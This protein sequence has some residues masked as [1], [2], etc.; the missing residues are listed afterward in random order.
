MLPEEGSDAVGG[1][2]NSS[3]RRAM[4]VIENED[5]SWN[6]SYHTPDPA[7]VWS[8]GEDEEADVG[9]ERLR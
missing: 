3:K 6:V 4:L 7:R 5:G 8:E 1:G 2:V 9:P